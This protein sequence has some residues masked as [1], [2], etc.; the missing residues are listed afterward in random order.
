LPDVIPDELRERLTE[1]ASS[2]DN[3]GMLRACQAA[4]ML[5]ADLPL[6][7]LERYLATQHAVKMAKLRYVPPRLPVTITHFIAE[8]HDDDW[9]MQGWD[10]RA[11]RV[12][13]VTVP[14]DHMTMVQTPHAEVLAARIS[15]AL[16]AAAAL[17]DGT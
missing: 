5:P 3:G 16:A 15:S 2:G 8:H 6:D 11:D 13:C 12:V 1:L 9:D 14:G 4:G 10:A 7:L 17:L